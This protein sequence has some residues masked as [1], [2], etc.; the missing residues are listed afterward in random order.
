MKGF[1]MPDNHNGQSSERDG[2]SS[3]PGVTTEHRDRKDDDKPTHRRKAGQKGKFHLTK[4][5]LIIGGAVLAVLLISVFIYWLHARNFQSTDDAYTTTHVHEISA[6][7]AGT[8]ET[9]NVNDNQFVKEGDT[10]VGLDP[11]DFKVA[12]EQARAMLL[13]RRAAADQAKANQTHAQQDYDRF[14]KLGREKVVSK[15]DVDNATAILKTANGALNA[16]KADLAAAEAALAN[17]ELQLSYTTIIAPADG[18]I[19]KKTVETGE[20][21]QPGQA[22]MAVVEQNVWVLGNFKETQLARMRVGQHVD[23]KIDGIPDH[24]FSAHIDSLQPGTGSTFALLPP[25]NATG[26][27]VKIV[28][29]VPVKIVLDDVGEY[30]DRVVPGLS[31]EPKVDLRSGPER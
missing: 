2:K 25:D 30:R 26:N 11:R 13:Q 7:V 10:L 5:T 16:A 4:R 27:F 15:Q 8:V 1:Q 20:R 12:A 22:L 28:Q 23:V 14:T 18:L 9:V 6:R 24:V 3:S 31:C 17:T 21:V 29:R 19:A